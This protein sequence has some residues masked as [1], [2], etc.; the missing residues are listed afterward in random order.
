MI[1]T[2]E[3]MEQ[4]LREMHGIDATLREQLERAIAAEE[5]EAAARLRDALRQRE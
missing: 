3:R 2:L 4:S 5:Y 1:Q